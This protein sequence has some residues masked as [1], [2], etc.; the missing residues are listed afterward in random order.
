MAKTVVG[1]FDRFE[2]AQNALQE[3]VDNG[4]DRNDISLVA[5][6]SRGQFKNYRAADRSGTG[7]FSTPDST[8][9]T[10]GA[11]GATA[12]AVGGGAIGGVLGLLVGIGALAIP[13][14]GP[15]LAAGPLVA[16]LGSAGAGAVAG[17]GIGAAS[18]GLIGG[19]VGLG[20]PDEDANFYAEGV[21]RGGT[22]LTVRTSDDLAERAADIMSRYNVV[23]VDTRGAE[24]RQSGWTGNFDANAKPYTDREIESFR[25]TRPTGTA[26]RTEARSRDLKQGEEVL[27]VVEEELQVGKRQVQ[28]GGARIH[29][30]VQERPVEEQVNLREEHVHVERRPVDRPVADADVNAFKERSFEVT[31]TTEEPVVSKRA[32]VV[33]EVVIS[34]DAQERTETVRDTVRRQ[35]VHVDEQG[36]ERSVGASGYDAFDSDFR[37]HFQ[38]HYANSGYSY[39]NYAPVYRYGYTLGT[40][41]RYG[42]DWSAVEP[43]AR[44]RWEERNPNSW[45][46]FK[47]SIR[48]A[49]DRA[50]GAR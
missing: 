26:S 34:K 20:I 49:W 10:Q 48:Y 14:I 37:N 40:D 24:W 46:E 11:E 41:R 4:I 5:N 23:D 6:D 30:E 36:A 15:V 9:G 8:G 19:L 21:R 45:D 38:S 44:R 2:D 33:E 12:G 35:D 18:G 47:D 50:R 42:E 16:A 1:L 25:S 32:R 43:E 39:D 22:L 17:A 27:P 29:T 28:R 31:E 7:D 13:G 3:L